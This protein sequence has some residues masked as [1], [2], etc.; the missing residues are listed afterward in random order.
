MSRIY[1]KL[2]A[3]AHIPEK[4][5]DC[6]FDNF[7]TDFMP[8]NAKR[9]KKM[10]SFA[11]NIF[12]VMEIPQ[13]AYLF[14]YR[15]GTGKT[16]IAV[17]TA[18]LA[19]WQFVK[20]IYQQN[21]F[22]YRRRGNNLNEFNH[23][24]P[25]FFMSEKNYL[26]KKKQYRTRNQEVLQE[27]ELIENAIINSDLLIIDDFFKER[28]TEF[29][30]G[31]LTAWLCQRYDYNKPVIFTSN[32]DF[33]IFRPGFEGNPYLETEHYYSATYLYSRIEEMTQGF[34]FVFDDY[35]DYREN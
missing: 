20:R 17:A 16:H 2:L 4:Y 35:K 26:W 3:N 31:E 11:E 19:L 6:T 13:S 23:Y 29:T 25:V 12:K 9:A 1:R 27:V 14:S 22:K 18:K 32:E 34:Q 5:L 15:N 28:D 24:A 8:E 33:K 21:P 10:K 7:D 30:F